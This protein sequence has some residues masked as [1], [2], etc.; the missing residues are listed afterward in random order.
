MADAPAPA[1]PSDLTEALA[2]AHLVDVFQALPP[3]HQAEYL[4]W[5]N[6]AKREETRRRR[7]EGTIARLGSA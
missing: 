4:H 3:S 7:I 5:I 1:L 2:A 6:E